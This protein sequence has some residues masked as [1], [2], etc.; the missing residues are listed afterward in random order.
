MN[1]RPD[2]Q[3]VPILRNTLP[4]RPTSLLLLILATGGLY[5]A[6]DDNAPAKD[7]ITFRAAPAIEALEVVSEGAE[8]LVIK[9]NAETQPIRKRSRDV[10][11]IDYAGMHE[12]DYRTGTEALAAGQYAA[13][14]DA[15]A[16]TAAN[17]RE[18][19]KVYGR[20]AQGDALEQAGK[21]TEAAVVFG[22]VV[23]GFKD[24]RLW[25]DAAYRQGMAQALAK[26]AAGAEKT[27]AVLSEQA[28]GKVGPPAEARANAIRTAIPFAAGNQA[29]FIEQARRVTFR[30]QSEPD[31]WYHFNLWMADAYRQ[32]QKPKDTA[33]IADSMLEALGDAPERKAQVIAMKGLALI[34]DDPA[35][36]LVELLKLD[37]LPFGSE[38]KKC[39]TRFEAGKLLLAEAT[40]LAAAPETAKDDMK[41][42]FVKELRATAK[43]V[44]AA[45][46]SSPSDQPAKAK[47]AELAR[48]ITD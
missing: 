18:W 45:A 27:A 39:E 42:A 19:Q 14:A 22:Q 10:I 6:D 20:L 2:R 24:H 13:A 48:T 30:A 47:A 12:G 11:A 1:D 29:K 32:I 36:A 43:L 38:L 8:E 7:R 31:A 41:K 35:S 3:S 33:R 44:L 40:R 21:F 34:A 23:T 28:K 37:A 5:A 46:A 9:V 16:K 25:L 15:F 17:P 4:M 26:D